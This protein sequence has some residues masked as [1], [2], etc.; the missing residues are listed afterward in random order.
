MHVL[1]SMI[2]PIALE[3]K[4]N[5][6]NLSTAF[7][8]SILSLAFLHEATPVNVVLESETWVLF[9]DVEF[10]FLLSQDFFLCLSRR[11][12]SARQI[13]DVR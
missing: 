2:L 11:N 12:M 8:A 3:L 6:N 1:L 9:L 10:S 5:I 4:R 13:L 7:Q